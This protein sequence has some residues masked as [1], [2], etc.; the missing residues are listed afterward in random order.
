MVPKDTHIPVFIA[1]LFTE[2]WMKR[3]WHIYTIEYYSVIKN[4]EIMPNAQH[5]WT[6]RLSYEVM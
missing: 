5:A 3:T 1:V 2:G 4:S 6:R